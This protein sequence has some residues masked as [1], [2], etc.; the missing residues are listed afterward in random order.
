MRLHKC[1]DKIECGANNHTLFLEMGLILINIKN[2]FLIVNT[3]T[4]K[5][6]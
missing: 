6:S 5:I 2:N 1:V 4:V 3:A